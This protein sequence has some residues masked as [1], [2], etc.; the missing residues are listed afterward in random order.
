MCSIQR[1]WFILRGAWYLW[2]HVKYDGCGN[3]IH[4]WE[5][6]PWAA[7]FKYWGIEE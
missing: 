4:L 1:L 5:A 2:R 3:R 7:D 6:I